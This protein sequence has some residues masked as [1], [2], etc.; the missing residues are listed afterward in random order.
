[1]STQGDDYDK[2]TKEERAVR[3]AADRAR[4]KAEQDALPYKWSQVLTD[5]DVIVPVPAGTRGRDLAVVLQKR[6]LSV[7]L[8]GKE[9]ILTGELFADI[10][11]EDSTWTLEDNKEVQIHLE[12]V[13]KQQWWPHILTH[14]PKID[15]TKIEP[16]NSKLSDLD[17]ETRGMVEKMMFDNQQK[18]MGKPTSDEMKKMETLRKFQDAHPELDFSNAKIT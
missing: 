6:K 17:G 2:L 5:A 18:Q 10:K 7:G 16:E 1:M 4:E 12:K 13:N 14:H 9:P 3:D 11:M 8:K 15:T